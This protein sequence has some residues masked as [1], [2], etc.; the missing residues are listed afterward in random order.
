MLTY[1][2]FADKCKICTREISIYVK[3]GKLVSTNKFVDISNETNKEFIQ[4]RA[5][6]TAIYMAFRKNGY[7]KSSKTEAII[8]CSMEDFRNH[9]ASLFQEGMSFDNYGQWHLDHITPLATASTEEDV[10]RLNHY[11]NLRPLWA[12]DNLKKG[13]KV[14]A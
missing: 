8:G 11:T 1:K 9:I 5:D 4:H 6:W 12:I 7:K 2:Q 13:S 14:A 10:L 3:R